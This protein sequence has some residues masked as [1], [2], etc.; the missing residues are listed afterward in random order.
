MI[1]N[2]WFKHDANARHDPLMKKIRRERGIA[3]KALYWDLIEMLRCGGGKLPIMETMIEVADDN[4][5]EDTSIVEYLI[6]QSGLFKF[7]DGL[8]WSERLLREI[9]FANE[10]A[11]RNRDNG[12]KGGRP[13]KITQEKPTEN[14]DETQ[15]KPSGFLD[16]TQTKPRK[17][18]N[19]VIVNSN[20]SL[21]SPSSLDKSN[22]EV[23]N[24]S[25][26]CCP[27]DN[28]QSL[29]PKK[30][31]EKEAENEALTNKQCQQVIDY[32]NKRIAETNA[33]FSKVAALSE[34]R[35]SKIRIR[36]KEFESIGKPVTICKIIFNKACQSKFLQGDN[37]NGWKA[38]FDWIFTNGKNW[39]KIY[40]GNYDN[41]EPQAPKSRTDKL[42]E[43]LKYIHD[44]FNP[45]DN[46]TET[47]TGIDDQ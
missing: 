11:T 16:K 34:A 21:L 31:G 29:F 32:W 6:K 41:N 37:N 23:S 33:N 20:S 42:Q 15:K 43:D 27:S 14:P 2:V 45:K 22:S 40:E 7:E 10:R 8:F 25:E 18:H 28:S 46:G 35:K 4:H 12:K 44:F 17:N 9:E 19:N 36:W 13:R 39:L 47:H 3:A 26:L 30:E 5:L 38:S 24:S 1:D